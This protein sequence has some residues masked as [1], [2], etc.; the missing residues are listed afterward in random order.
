MAYD[1]TKNQGQNTQDIDSSV[2]GLPFISIIQKGS[3][4]FDETHRLHNVKK[5]ADC[6]PGNILFAQ[7]RRVLSQPMLVIPV[8]Q[9]ALYTEWKPRD[10]G[11]GFL[12]NRDVTVVTE[13]GY[14]KGP[15]GSNTANR[16]YLGNNE[17]MFSIYFMFLFK[18][19]QDWTKGM[20][21]FTQTQLKHARGWLRMVGGVA[22]PEFPGVKPPI[23]AA[24][25]RLTTQADSNTK[26]GWFGWNVAQDRV[27]DLTTDEAL[28]T[29]AEKASVEAG[30]ALQIGAS[31][32]QALP[33][34]TTVTAEV[35]PY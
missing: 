32:Q 24:T 9:T 18:D 33:S 22:Y 4:E 30:T 17:L 27:L 28:L 6:K 14:R 20:I 8:H 34:T 15:V 1:P 10:Q 13:R 21:S 31:T 12:G 5:I 11:G 25:Y 19:G 26:G 7:K 29:M 16:E 35:T 2:L 23:F 3:P